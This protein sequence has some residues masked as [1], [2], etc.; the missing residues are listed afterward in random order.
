MRP[1]A[2]HDATFLAEPFAIRA[3]LQTIVAGPVLAAVDPDTRAVT[4]LV[5]AEVLNNVA[6]HAYAGLGGPVRLRIRLHARGLACRIAD[7]GARMPDGRPPDGTAAGPDPASL[8]QGGFGWP[9]IRALTR[10]LRYRRAAGYN[11]LVFTVPR[12]S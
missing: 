7:G 10:G 1:D 3:A 11:V 12:N 4:E 5:L 9:L 2:C 8:P 6:E